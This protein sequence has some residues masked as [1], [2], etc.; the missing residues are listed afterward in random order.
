MAKERSIF[1]M[2]LEL[3]L[4]I[5][6][7]LRLRKQSQQEHDEADQA[8]DII[9]DDVDNVQN[10]PTDEDDPLGTGGWNDGK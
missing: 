6:E 3:A 9:G 8:E 10:P 2:L 5:L 1:R 4:R 7:F